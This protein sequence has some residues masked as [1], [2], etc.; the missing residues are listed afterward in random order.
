MNHEQRIT[1][2]PLAVGSTIR[3]V[4]IF[5][6]EGAVRLNTSGEIRI[7]TRDQ[8]K[9]TLERPLL[10]HSTRTIDSG[11][12]TVVGT[13]Q[14]QRCA[15]RDEVGCGLRNHQLVSIQAVDRLTGIQRIEL[16]A[17]RG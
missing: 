4:H 14:F 8:N 3:V 13:K 16:D 1:S 2:K 6:T 12:K 9:I 10:V 5:K 7:A 15:F 11:V 17:E